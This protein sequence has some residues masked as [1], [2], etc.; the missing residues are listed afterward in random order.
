MLVK[1]KENKMNLS[2]R[3]WEYIA[4]ELRKDLREQEKFKDNPVFLKSL[5]K[6]VNKKII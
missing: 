6:K 3:E 4:Q 1:Q 2:K 5:I